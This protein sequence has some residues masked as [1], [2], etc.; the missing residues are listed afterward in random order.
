MVRGTCHV[1]GLTESITGI[2]D[3]QNYIARTLTLILV[4]SP[5]GFETWKRTPSKS[6]VRKTRVFLF[7]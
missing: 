2:T 4:L 6:V 7:D 1:H 3:T 5:S